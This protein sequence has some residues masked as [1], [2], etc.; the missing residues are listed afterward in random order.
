MNPAQI[1]VVRVFLGLLQDG[2]TQ[3]DNS[4]RT[5][6]RNDFGHAHLLQRISCLGA[7]LRVTAWDL[8]AGVQ[9]LAC[10]GSRLEI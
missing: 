7:G 8:G 10:L 3:D 6:L 5:W 9:G 1:A 2:L 4:V